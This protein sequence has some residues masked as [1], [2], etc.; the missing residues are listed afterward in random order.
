[1]H[2]KDDATGEYGSIP[3]VTGHGADHDA[4]VLWVNSA[5]TWVDVAPLTKNS[6]FT[7]FVSESGV[8]ELFIMASATS[9]KRILKNLAAITGHAQ[10]PPIYSLGFHF[11]KYADVS[12]EIMM[13]RDSDFESYGFPVDVFWMDIL[14]APGYKYFIFDP[15]KFP[16]VG[17]ESMNN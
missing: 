6:S 12:S 11:S 13:Q 15:H 10:L 14:Y 16:P 17:L 9:P 5:D 7:G 8:I 2:Q 3:Y 4:S 1:M